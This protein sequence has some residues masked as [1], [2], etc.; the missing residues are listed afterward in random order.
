MSDLV[1]INIKQYIKFLVGTDT[2]LSEKDFNK[3]DLAAI[4]RA[5]IRRMKENPRSGE[6]GYGDYGEQ[7]ADFSNFEQGA[8]LRTLISDSYTDP[9]MRLET[10][11]GM[12]SYDTD[13][14]GDVRVK[15]TYNFN[16]TR[17]QVN[18]IVKEQGRLGA[19]DYALRKNGFTGILNAIGNMYGKTEDEGGT[20]VDINLGKIRANTLRTK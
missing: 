8:S 18:E 11:L 10:T 14:N 7:P 13:D 1:P 17:K 16:A 5:V 3:E 6:I 2:S 20:N 15:D 9:K 4:K 19:M 12:A